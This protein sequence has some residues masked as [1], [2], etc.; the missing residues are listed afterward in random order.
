LANLITVHS[1]LVELHG[2]MLTLVAICILATVVARFHFSSRKTSGSYGI[3]WPADSFM[4][5]VAQYAEPTA[6]VAAIGGAIG[7]IASA[8]AGLYIYPM[9][10]VESSSL[11]LGK[12]A[13]SVFT[14][15]LMLVFVFF[16][17]KYGQNL[18]KGRGTAAVYACTGLAGFVFMVLTASI[19]GHMAGKG[20]VLDPLYTLMKIN[21]ENLGFTQSNFPII[22][23][24]ITIVVLV[25]PT[26]AFMYF[27]R[28]TIHKS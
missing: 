9:S 3:F 27:Q 23:I 2:G 16:R 24:G 11:V 26:L 25:F 21:P 20:S 4:G 13:F 22:T 14:L 15:D 1:M 28:K 19:G 12:I 17:S 5:K 18:W 10:F 8:V 6:Y 7:L